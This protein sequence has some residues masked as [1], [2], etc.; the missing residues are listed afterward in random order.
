M[1]EAETIQDGVLELYQRFK[2]A[3]YRGVYITDNDAE[4]LW[5]TYVFIKYVR[6]MNDASRTF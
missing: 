3:K 1:R 2:D 4:L 6:M 5:D